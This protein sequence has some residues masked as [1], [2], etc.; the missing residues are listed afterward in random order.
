M[1][2]A[3]LCRE[4]EIPEHVQGS[5][6]GLRRRDGRVQEKSPRLRIATPKEETGDTEGDLIGS[7]LHPI[8]G[9]PWG[10]HVGYG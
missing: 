10:R 8:I 4:V 3:R 2:K 1:E 6:E 9:T 5:K 7:E